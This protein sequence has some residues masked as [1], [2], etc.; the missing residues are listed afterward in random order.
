MLSENALEILTARYFKQ[1]PDGQV[2]EDADGLFR[3]VARA[4]AAAE[5]HDRPAWEERFYTAMSGLE[6]LPNSPTLMNAGLPE[7][8]L[9]A[10]FVLPVPDRLEEIFDALTRTALIHQ[11]GGG[12]GFNFSHLRPRGDRVGG[13]QGTASGPVGFIKVFDAAT[14]Q[15]KQGG[16]RRGANMGI[17]N[18][19]HPDI[20]EF[21]SRVSRLSAGMGEEGA[22]KIIE[23]LAAAAAR[24][25]P[26][27]LL[28]AAARTDQHRWHQCP[29]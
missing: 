22:G 19:D 24:A 7:G 28:L 11:S 20:L 5:Q 29:R 15:I 10:C 18:A 12:T 21:I 8:Q 6:F 27:C 2:A 16:R 26:R 3:R 23:S 17:L 9:S 25:K 14:E 1:G 4:V 13:G